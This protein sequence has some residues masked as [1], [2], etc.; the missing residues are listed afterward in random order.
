MTD[1]GLSVFRNSRQINVLILNNTGVTDQGLSHFQGCRRLG[2][3]YLENTAISD[4]G[5]ENLRD[6]KGIA[7]I[8]LTGTRVT[9][10]GLEILKDCSNL[11]RLYLDNT[12]ITDVALESLP[13]HHTVLGVISLKATQVTEAGVMKLAAALPKCRIEWDGG[14]IEPTGV[15]NPVDLNN[16]TAPSP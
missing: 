3:L 11:M 10:A 14:V 15:A 16:T 4:K 7:Y 5:L 8:H 1:A 13:K 6:C 12:E 2:Q 9:E